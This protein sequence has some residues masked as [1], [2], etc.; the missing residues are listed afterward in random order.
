MGDDDA[1][2]AQHDWYHRHRAA[3]AAA[4]ADTSSAPTASQS[5]FLQDLGE[6]GG[7]GAGE[8]DCEECG[9]VFSGIGMFDE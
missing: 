4:E 2:F 7:D 3:L 5:S 8:D 6:G 9:G 1:R